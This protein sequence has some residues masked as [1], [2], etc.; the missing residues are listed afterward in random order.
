MDHD[1]LEKII[2]LSPSI[3]V[4]NR[5]AGV[6]GRKIRFRPGV[7]GEISYD[8]E[9]GSSQKCYGVSSL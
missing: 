9:A 4:N 8:T 5:R 7:L 3:N 1:K 6:E 2:I